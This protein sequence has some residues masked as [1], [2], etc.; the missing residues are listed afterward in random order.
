MSKMEYKDIIAFHPGFYINEIIEDMDITQEEFAKRA[1]LTPK[2]LSDLLHGKA[3]ITIDVATKLSSML[4]TSIEMWFNLQNQY[5][6]QIAEIKKQKN[7]DEQIRILNMIDT[8]FFYKLGLLPSKVSKVESVS[9]LCNLLKIS[10]LNVLLRPDLSANF[11]S[12]SSAQNEKHIVNANAWLETAITVSKKIEVSEYDSQKLKSYLPEIR[13]MTLKDPS[14]FLPKLKS[15]FSEC[16]VSFVLLPKMTNAKI[17][18]VVKWLSNDKAL[19]AMN[20]RMTYADTFWFSLFHEIKHI[21][22]HKTSQVMISYKDMI[23]ELNQHYEDEAN[24]FAGDYL[25]PENALKEYLKTEKI[26]K[27]SILSFA[28][29][30]GIH[31]G[32]VV[33]R[34]QNDKVIPYSSMNELRQKYKI[35]YQIE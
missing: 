6:F 29:K 19:I 11:R 25:I 17:N 10:S 28:K 7:I 31:P 35:I 26:T 32:I 20:D 33:G 23:Y 30:I 16:G 15:I 1:E 2:H 27:Q 5:N 4:N 21:F 8:T 9:I 12:T 18:G 13:S 14:V 22:Q 24:K 34:L 3:G